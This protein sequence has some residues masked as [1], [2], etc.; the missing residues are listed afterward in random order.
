MKRTILSFT[1]LLLTFFSTVIAQND[2]PVSVCVG[3]ERLLDLLT[4]EQKNTLT[5]LTITGTMAEEDYAFIRTNRLKKIVELNLRDADIEML[6]E[7][8]FDFEWS[9]DNWEKT[10]V[11]PLK[12]KYL[13]DYSLCVTYCSCT[14]ILTGDYP[15]LGL[16]VYH[17]D[18][19]EYMNEMIYI[20]PSEDN[21]FLKSKEDFVYSKDGI[22]VYYYK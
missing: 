8:A 15:E 21:I 4:E 7:H 3:E 22:M 19:G 13:S 14:Y 17:S 20:Y 11:L 16:N 18:A 5:H 12:L 1:I 10:I 2:V 9:G 6:P